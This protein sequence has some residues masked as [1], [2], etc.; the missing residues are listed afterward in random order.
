MSIP[1]EV[2][3]RPSYEH[4]L[5]IIG[6]YLDAEPAYYVTVVEVD[7]GFAVRYSPTRQRSETRSTQ[8]SWE[9]LRNLKIFNAAGRGTGKRTRRNFGLWHELPAGY[10]DFFRALGYVLDDKDATSVTIDS[11]PKGVAVSYVCANAERPLTPEKCY[12]IMNREAI[13][14]MIV[15]AQ[16]RRVPPLRLE[17]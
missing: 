3:A 15:E 5:R 17:G 10:Q 14:E 7:D 8:F 11:L 9:R 12:D 2:H 13:E 4:A 1:A 6:R 16:R